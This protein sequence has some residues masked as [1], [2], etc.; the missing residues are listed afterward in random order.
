MSKNLTFQ[1]DSSDFIL[2]CYPIIKNSEDL[3]DTE[4]LL[5]EFEQFGQKLYNLE[6]SSWPLIDSKKVQHLWDACQVIHSMRHMCHYYT[7]NEPPFFFKNN[8]I[9][10]AADSNLV[11]QSL[12]HV[13][14]NTLRDQVEMGHLVTA[15]W[16]IP[17][18]FS[19]D[20]PYK[21]IKGS[22]TFIAEH[23]I[24]IMHKR[25]PTHKICLKTTQSAELFFK[26]IGFSSSHQN[27]RMCLSA[28]K[29]SLITAK[30][31]KSF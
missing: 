25:Y 16:N 20:L 11:V 5:E 3:V 27:S 13:F 17:N 26:K 1:S 9:F 7:L 12:A 22:G 8:Y 19:D 10:L 4:N 18:S 30:I 14:F 24:A 6:T 23:A 15:P 29:A 2:K 21:R 31:F 28:A